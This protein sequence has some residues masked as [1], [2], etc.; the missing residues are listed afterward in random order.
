MSENHS[1][2]SKI[3][4]GG[5]MARVEPGEQSNHYGQE[6]F[7][8]ARRLFPICPSITGIGGRKTFAI[9]KESM[10]ALSIQEVPSGTQ[11]FD[12]RVPDEWN[13]EDAI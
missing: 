13:I 2:P 4:Q 9:L 6:C 12:W 5:D 11:C 7:N 8:L 1:T 10:S 3:C